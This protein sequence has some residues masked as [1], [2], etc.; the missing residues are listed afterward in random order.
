E[1]D[2]R[3]PTERQLL[4]W[5][6]ALLVVV[7]VVSGVLLIKSTGR[8][9]AHVRVIAALVNV[10]DGLP[11]RSDVKYHGVLVGAVTDV[12]PAKYGDPNF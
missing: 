7:T 4:A 8:M 10:G 9:D 1:L 12:T 6:V 11:Q 3:G 2:G 5:G